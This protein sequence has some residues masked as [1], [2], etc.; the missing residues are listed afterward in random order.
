MQELPK[1]EFD[2]I[3]CVIQSF[4]EFEFADFGIWCWRKDQ[5]FAFQVQAVNNLCLFIE[6]D[7][8]GS[9]V[10]LGLHHIICR[11]DMENQYII[12]TVV[13]QFKAHFVQQKYKRDRQL[14]LGE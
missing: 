8:H 10:P 3:R 12:H 1:T 14:F 5:L 2:T 9:P 7:E 6:V 13:S 4:H 11:Q